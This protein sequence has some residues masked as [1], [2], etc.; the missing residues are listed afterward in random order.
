VG[1]LHN[2]LKFL[3]QTMSRRI[4]LKH[5]LHA[6]SIPAISTKVYLQRDLPRSGGQKGPSR[7]L[8]LI[9]GFRGGMRAGF[10]LGVFGNS[11]TTKS[12]IKS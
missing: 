6:G 1:F 4:V 11:A 12:E 9:L 10:G 3:K 5:F 2:T 8:S 7:V